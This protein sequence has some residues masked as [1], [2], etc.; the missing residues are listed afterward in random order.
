MNYLVKATPTRRLAELSAVERDALMPGER[1]AAEALIDAGVLVWMW[2][3]PDGTTSLSIWQADDA[4]VLGERLLTLPL[5]PYHD[6]E[7][8]ALASHPA[9][10]AP[11]RAGV[12]E[13]AV[14]VQAVDVRA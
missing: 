14:D 11:L 8:T 10:P 2:R 1:A 7:I 9:F 6:L 13:G 12:A 4:E 5:H 3:S